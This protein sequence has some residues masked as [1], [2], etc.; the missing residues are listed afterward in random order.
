MNILHAHFNKKFYE[1]QPNNIFKFLEIF[2][3]YKFKYMFVL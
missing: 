1:M 2:I 3:K